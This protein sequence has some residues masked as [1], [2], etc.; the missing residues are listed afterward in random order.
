MNFNTLFYFNFAVPVER[1]RPRDPS[2]YTGA[3][4]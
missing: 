4:F 3:H 1:G 2:H